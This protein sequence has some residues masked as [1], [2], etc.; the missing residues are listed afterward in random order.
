MLLGCVW[1]V[2]PSFAAI[3]LDDASLA[4]ES[5]HLEVLTPMVISALKENVEL[6][7]ENQKIIYDKIVQQRIGDQQKNMMV[8]SVLTDYQLQKK[9]ENLAG[10]DEK[11]VAIPT[12]YRFIGYGV[13]AKDNTV[14]VTTED[15]ITIYVSRDSP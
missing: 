5:I 9:E 12:K 4:Q 3:Y 11:Q 10:L 15:K 8:N 1:G 2:S 7:A 13:S 14:R 6:S